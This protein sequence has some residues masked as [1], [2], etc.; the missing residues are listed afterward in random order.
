MF[1]IIYNLQIIG[2]LV[3]DNLQIIGT[4]VQDN[5]QIIGTLVQDNMISDFEGISGL[6]YVED[7]LSSDQQQNILD[8]VLKMNFEGIT[9]SNSRRVVQYGYTYSYDRSG[10]SKTNPIPDF[11]SEL[12]TTDIMQG[13]GLDFDQKFDQLIINEYKT[14]QKISPHTDHIKQFGDTIACISLGQVVDLTFQHGDIIKKINA[15]A[16]SMYVMTGDARYKWKHSLSNNKKC[17]RY[18]LTFR[19]K[20]S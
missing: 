4:L 17:T 9:G 12:V 5:L 14:G 15:K 3:Q 1:K 18:S 13:L 6:F 11:L 7:F 16:G 10:L 20:Q 8:E 19:I 2:T